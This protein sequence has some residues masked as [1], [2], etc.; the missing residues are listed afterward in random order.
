MALSNRSKVYLKFTSILRTG[1]SQGKGSFYMLRFPTFSLFGWTMC[2]YDQIHWGCGYWAWGRFRQQCTKEYRIGETC[3]L[4]LVFETDYRHG[5]CILCEKIAKKQGRIRKMTT[6]IAR[7]KR[8]GN[9][10]AT[11]EKTER[12]LILVLGSM[13]TLPKQHN[14][15]EVVGS[16]R[17]GRRARHIGN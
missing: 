3:G 4:W 5:Y 13:S 17:R 9:K 12:E 1:H 10:P 11:V 8:D 14:K 6:D 7:W 15:G 2:F 16:G